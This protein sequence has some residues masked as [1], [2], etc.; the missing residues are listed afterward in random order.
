MD[1]L[2]TELVTSLAKL[3][4][5]LSDIFETA[6]EAIKKYDML[7]REV[8]RKIPTEATGATFRTVKPVIIA[9]FSLEG[10][11]LKNELICLNKNSMLNIALYDTRMVALIPSTLHFSYRIGVIELAK[12]IREK[13]VIP[14]NEQARKYS[15][16]VVDKAGKHVELVLVGEV[17]EIGE[18]G[19]PSIWLKDKEEVEKIINSFFSGKELNR[20]NIDLYIHHSYDEYSIINMF[21]R[22]YTN[23][24]PYIGLIK[25][26]W[27]KV[28]SKYFSD[29][30]VRAGLV[31]VNL[32]VK[33][34]ILLTEK[35]L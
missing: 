3:A 15:N 26:S 9:T 14:T 21:T 18:A 7:D 11:L 20:I 17:D 6:S 8:E 28:A 22:L 1:E 13:L 19:A 34:I 31:A 23:P 16:L 33:Q 5:F 27:T 25:K 24:K 32:S 29:T 10:K 35:L 2:G 12:L 30:E 4:L